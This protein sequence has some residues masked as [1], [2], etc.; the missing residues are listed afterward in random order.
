M[1]YKHQLAKSTNTQD[2]SLI[3]QDIKMDINPA[4]AI[5]DTIKMD[6]NPAYA[7]SKW[8][9]NMLHVA[10]LIEI[11]TSLRFLYFVSIPWM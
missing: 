7:V 10:T 9:K 5:M 6:T 4:Y 2:N 11:V 3:D 8:L 1:Y